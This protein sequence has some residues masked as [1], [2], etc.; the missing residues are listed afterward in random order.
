MLRG[1]ETFAHACPW[2][3][4]SP[5]GIR[6]VRYGQSPAP[7]GRDAHVAERPGGLLERPPER[8]RPGHGIFYAARTPDEIT[9]GVAVVGE[10]LTGG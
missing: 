3:A 9:E 6:M 5:G 7:A 2:P 4:L 8:E 10:V 1:S